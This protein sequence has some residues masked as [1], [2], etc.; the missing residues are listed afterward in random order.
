MRVEADY[1]SVVRNYVETLEEIEKYQ[2]FEN[3]NF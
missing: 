1:S 3:N 2:E